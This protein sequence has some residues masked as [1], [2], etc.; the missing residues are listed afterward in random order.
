VKLKARN[1]TLAVA[2]GTGRAVLILAFFE[3]NIGM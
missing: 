2:S 1:L 3:K